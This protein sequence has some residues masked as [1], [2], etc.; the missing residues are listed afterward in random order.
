MSKTC[1]EMD[2][3]T[4]WQQYSQRVFVVF[5]YSKSFAV[6]SKAFSSGESRETIL[7]ILSGAPEFCLIKERQ[8]ETRAKQCVELVFDRVYYKHQTLK[9][10]IHKNLFDRLLKPYKDALNTLLSYKD[11]FKIA[12]ALIQLI[13]LSITDFYSSD[14]ETEIRDLKMFDT[15][16]AE[17]VEKYRIKRL[18]DHTTSFDIFLNI[19]GSIVYLALPP[20]LLVILV[21]YSQRRP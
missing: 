1:K 8:G 20:I 2:Y 16:W 9:Y 18:L 17:Q 10:K 5:P 13:Y 6:A 4:L 7:Q 19:L 3:A 11:Y 21:M 15:E 12:Q 14:Q